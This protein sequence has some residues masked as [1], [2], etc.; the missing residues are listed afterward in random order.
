MQDE[1]LF[2]GAKEKTSD[3]SGPTLSGRGRPRA[4]RPRSTG[5]RARAT[6]TKPGRPTGPP[7]QTDAQR[8]AAAGV[9][10]ATRPRT[11]ATGTTGSS[12]PADEPRRRRLRP[13]PSRN[14]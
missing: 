4:A 14:G 5:S 6:Q 10:R 1:I 9:E 3:V 7:E 2:Q 12:A 8:R 13:K 11:T